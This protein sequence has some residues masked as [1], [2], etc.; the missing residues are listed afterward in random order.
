MP[1]YLGE[2]S[3]GRKG[4][5]RFTGRRGKRHVTHST[6]REKGA[7]PRQPR[8]REETISLGGYLIHI[9]D[10]P[11]PPV[12]GLTETGIG[13]IVA[14]PEGPLADDDPLGKVEV[15]LILGDASRMS[16]PEVQ[17]ILMA[18]DPDLRPLSAD[19]GYDHPQQ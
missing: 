17:T 10:I 15:E 8:S 7:E 13:R 5:P 14:T 12:P 18:F 19:P 11:T 6:G 3:Q 16:G 1:D 9:T 4:A 2:Y